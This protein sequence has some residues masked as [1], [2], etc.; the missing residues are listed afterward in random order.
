MT[1]WNTNLEILTALQQEIIRLGIQDNPSRTV[2]QRMYDRNI[3]PNPNSVITRT[4]M[5]WT[6]IIALLNMKYDSK[7]GMASGGRKGGK[8]KNKNAGR[9]GYSKLSDEE[10]MNLITNEFNQNHFHSLILK[11]YNVLSIVLIRFQVVLCLTYTFQA[12]IYMGN[13]YFDFANLHI[14]QNLLQH[15]CW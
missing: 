8:T 3:A 4:G 10:F 13:W 7:A 2:Y 1:K 15:I 14:V 11:Y 6:E 5:K 9:K 12:L